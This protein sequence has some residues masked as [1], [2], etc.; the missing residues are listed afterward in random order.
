MSTEDPLNIQCDF[1]TYTLILPSC[2]SQSSFPCAQAQE[3]RGQLLL[4]IL[5]TYIPIY[6]PLSDTVKQK[7]KGAGCSVSCLKDPS[8]LLQ[9]DKL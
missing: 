9:L 3:S 8:G 5:M 7:I 6:H 1:P 4:L 2:A